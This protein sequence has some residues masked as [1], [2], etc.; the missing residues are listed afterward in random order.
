MGTLFRDFLKNATG[1][2]LVISSKVD[3]LACPRKREKED[4]IRRESKKGIREREGTKRCKGSE[5]RGARFGATDYASCNTYT[6]NI[7]AG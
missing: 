3:S 1:G 2:I 4:E 7:E 6:E 5:R